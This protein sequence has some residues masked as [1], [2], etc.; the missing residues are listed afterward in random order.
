LG[1]A[2]K[3]IELRAPVEAVSRFHPKSRISGSASDAPLAG[4]SSVFNACILNWI[5]LNL[6]VHRVFMHRV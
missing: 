6:D 1:T 3:S 4:C 5:H 2:Q